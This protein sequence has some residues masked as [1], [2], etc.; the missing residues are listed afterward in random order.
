MISAEDVR[1]YLRGELAPPAERLGAAPAPASGGSAPQ[2]Q[3]EPGNIDVHRRPVHRNMGGSISTV[4]TIGIEQDGKEYVIPTI[5]DDG[6]ALNQEQAVE[7]FRR[8][9]KHLGAFADRA[10]A[11]AFAQSLHEDQAKEYSGQEPAP[12]ADVRAYLRSTKPAAAPIPAPAGA[13]L[14]DQL[15]PPPGGRARPA[16]DVTAARGGPPP[17]TGLAETA[18]NTFVTNLLP[19]SLSKDAEDQALERADP[20]AASRGAS[21]IGAA[22]AAGKVT[23]ETAYMVAL[24]PV[25]EKVGGFLAGI[26]PKVY[27]SQIV[28]P[29]ADAIVEKTG[30]SL[31]LA[32]RVAG[33]VAGAIEGIVHGAAPA[34]AFGA[35]HDVME[36]D[37]LTPESL[38]A[39]GAGGSVISGVL[40]LGAG[41][42]SLAKGVAAPGDVAQT[43]RDPYAILGVSPEASA[44]EILD[45]ARRRS[46][47]FHPDQNPTPGAEEVFKT[48]QEA[49]N[50]ALDRIHSRRP[51]EAPESP[52][53]GEPPAAPQEAGPV[54]EAQPAPEQAPPAANPTAPGEALA[55]ELGGYQPAKTVEDLQLM[56]DMGVP[57]VNPETGRTRRQEFAEQQRQDREQQ[58]PGAE[59]AAA[60]GNEPAAPE[61][62]PPP[63]EPQPVTTPE[64]RAQIE[65]QRRVRNLTEQGKKPNADEIVSMYRDILEQ[66]PVYKAT[67]DVP[68]E[69]PRK[70]ISL[71]PTVPPPSSAPL[72]ARA[73]AYTV[74]PGKDL[75]VEPARF[76]YK[77][78]PDMA[79]GAGPE[80]KGVQRW[81]PDF[82]GVVL[83]WRDPAD[84]RLKVVN[85]HH[86]VDLARRLGVDA[87]LV[88]EINA[89]SAEEARAIGAMTNIA[90]GRG[91][92][93]DAAKVFRDSGMT[94]EEIERR[95]LP[96]RGEVAREGLALAQV[97]PGLFEL[98]ARG[99]EPWRRIA[100]LGKSGLSQPEQLAT[101]H[102]VQAEEAKGRR[103][104]NEQIEELARFAK[105]AETERVS[106][107]SLFGTETVD[108]SNAVEKARL[109]AWAKDKL[110]SQARLFKFVS[111]GERAEQLEGAGV[112]KVDA[113][114][115]GELAG[116]AEQVAEV[117]ERLSASAGPVS[118]ALNRALREIKA[119]ASEA[120]VRAGL[121]E[122]I[123]G[124]VQEVLGRGEGAGAGRAGA[125]DRDQPGLGVAE[126]PGDVYRPEAGAVV[127][128]G[129]NPYPTAP[130]PFFSRLDRAIERA[131]FQRAPAVQWLG[132]LRNAPGGLSKSE[133]D[134]TQLES[135]LGGLGTEKVTGDEVLQRA[136]Q[137]GISL[138]ETVKGEAGVAPPELVQARDD[139]LAAMDRAA[140][141]ARDAGEALS[142]LMRKRGYDA[143]E[144]RRA[145]FQLGDVQALAREEQAAWARA[146]AAVEAVL[147]G[148]DY[149]GFGSLEEA[150]NAA[151]REPDSWDMPERDVAI[152]RRAHEARKAL[153][154][155][156]D[157]ELD[158]ELEAIRKAFVRAE[159]AHRDATAAYQRASDAVQEHFS[160]DRPQYAGWTEPGGTNYREILVQLK[161]PGE[162]G[163]TAEAAV[164]RWKEAA[165]A[166]RQGRF[167][168][169][170]I[171]R[172][173]ADM[174]DDPAAHYLEL[175]DF[176]WE[177]PGGG[178]GR[179]FHQSHFSEPNVVVH[180]RTKDRERLT[181]TPQ[182]IDDIERR[183][184]EALPGV[185][186]GNIASGAPLAAVRKGAIT[187]LE[188]AQFA[189]ARGYAN[190]QKGAVEKVLGV[191][192]FQSD[193][194]REGRKQ[195]Y[196]TGD[197]AA[198]RGRIL[199]L[200]AEERAI[201]R[202]MA[203]MHEREIR[204]PDAESELL[205]RRTELA[206]RQRELYHE[207][208]RLRY[209]EEQALG[210]VPDQPFKSASEWVE[211]AFKR[212]LAEAVAGGYDR[213]SWVNGEMSAR[214]Y[215]LRKHISR[216]DY[217]EKASHLAAY[218]SRGN[219]VIT[220][221][222]VRP[223]DLPDLIGAELA[224]R[225][226]E[227]Q[228]G[229]QGFT[230]RLVPES[231]LRHS[232]GGRVFAHWDVM[233]TDGR[234]A[235]S[236][237]AEFNGKPLTEA[238]AIQ[239]VAG[240]IRSI[241]GEE[242]TVGG[243]SHLNL[244]DKVVP[245]VARDVLKKIGVNARIEPIR[246]SFAAHEGENADGTELWE[247]DS[248]EAGH[249]HALR[250][251]QQVLSVPITPE[252]RA[253]VRD[254]GLRVM[255]RAPSYDLF[256]NAVQ[257]PA[258]QGD[259]LKTGKPQGVG[260][261]LE[262]ARATVSSL[263]GRVQ[264][265]RATVGELRRYEEARSLVRRQEG[266]G[267]DA[268]E[269]G[270][271]A[272]EEKP[273]LDPMVGDL[274][275]VRE[276][277]R[278]TRLNAKGEPEELAGFG[279]RRAA[280]QASL[281]LEQMATQIELVFHP[282]L[283]YQSRLAR[284]KQQGHHVDIRGHRI[285]PGLKGLQQTYRLLAPFRSPKQEIFHVILLDG[286]GRVVAHTLETSGKVDFVVIGK[287]TGPAAAMRRRFVAEV[288]D[289][290]RRAGAKVVIFAHNHPSGNPTPS[291]DDRSITVSLEQ[292]LR[293]LAP[294][295]QVAGHMVIDH[296]TAEW[297][298]T[299]AV[300][301]RHVTET[302]V[303]IPNAGVAS[304]WLEGK[305]PSVRSPEDVARAVAAAG[306]IPANTA[307]MVWLDGQNGTI[308]L[309]PLS[310][311]AVARIE[312]W[313]DQR[314]T[315]IGAARGILVT[316]GAPAFR[317]SV[318]A[319]GDARLHHDGGIIDVLHLDENPAAPPRMSAAANGLLD[320]T[321]NPADFGEVAP[322]RRL[323]EEGPEY[324]AGHD[325]DAIASELE[326]L[327]AN[328]PTDVERSGGSPAVTGQPAEIPTRAQTRRPP[329]PND[330]RVV[331]AP[332][333][334]IYPTMQGA[335]VPAGP[336]KRGAR[337]RAPH[338]IRAIA[339]IT[340]A[341]GRAIPLRVGRMGTRSA[342]GIF[343][344]GPEVMRTRAAN[345][346]PTAA[347]EAAH[348][349]EK[350]LYG[351]KKGGP[352]KANVT[353][354]DKAQQDELVALG[355]ALYGSTKPAGG[356]KREGFA[357]YLR[358]WITTD[359]DAST[360]APAFTSWWLD[361]LDGHPEIKKQV[362]AARELAT[363]W[364][365]QGSRVRAEESV[366]DTGSIEERAK[367]FGRAARSLFT[368]E[369]TVEAAQPLYELA[370]AAEEKIGPLK[371]T[372]DPFLITSALRSTHHAR[373]RVM[374]EDGMIDL[375]GNVVGDPLAAIKEIIKPEQRTDFTIYLWARRA[376]KLWEG[377][378]EVT[379]TNPQTGRL[380][381]VDVPNPR[382]P[383]L[384]LEDAKQILSELD[385][386][387]F[388]LA[389]S[390][391]YEWNDGV[392]N[393]A[394]QASP[395]F[396]EIVQQVRDGDVGDY[397]P[398]HRVFDD[399][400]DI[401]TRSSR[402][403]SAGRRSPVKRLKGSG[404]EIKDPFPVMIA[405]AAATVRAAHQ[406]AV[407]DA[408]LKL[409]RVEG[410]GYLIEEVPVDQVPA[411][412][413][414]VGEI[415]DR[416]NKELGGLAD[417]DVR[418][419][420]GVKA[421]A[422]AELL[423]KALTFFAPAQ[424]P[425]GMDPIVPLW[426]GKRVRW[427]YVD[428]KLYEALSSLDVYRLPDV[429]GFPLLEWTLGKSASVVRLG[430]TG[431]RASFGLIWNPFR[432]VQ[433]LYVNTRSGAVAPRLFYTWLKAMKDGALYRTVGKE[434]GPYFQAFLRLGGD[435]AQALGEDTQPAR[436]A[437][438]RLFEGRVVRTIDPR[439][440]LDWF[441]D[442]VQAP[443]AAPRVAE[444]ELLAEKV[445]WK[446]GQPMTLAQSFELLLGA[447]QV[448]TD[449]TAAGE[450]ARVA[451]RMIPFFNAAIQGPR[452]NMRAAADHPARFAWRGLQLT[453]VSL[454]LWWA[455]KDEDWWKQ[456]DY[457][458]KFANWH[459]PFRNPVTGQDELLRLPR[460][461]E[462]GLVFSALP[463]AI[464]DSWY[465]ADPRSAEEFMTYALEVAAPPMVP[466][467][468][469]EV[470]EQARNKD[471]YFNTPIVP[472]GELDLPASLQYNE[473]TNRASVL[474]GRLFADNVSPETL[475]Q[476]GG[477][478]PRR[479]D[480]AINGLFG[481]TAGDIFQL[482]GLG[483]PKK[484]D[485]VGLE[486]KEPADIPV[487]GRA[488]KRGGP[489][490][491]RPKAFD[492]LY[493]VL[494]E[495]QRV[496]AVVGDDETVAHAQ[497]RLMLTDAAQAV[498]ALTLVRRY[499]EDTAK[500]RALTQEALSIAE[501][502]LEDAKDGSVSRIDF[503][504]L[505]RGAQ[506][507]AD[508]AMGKQPARPA[509]ARRPSTRRR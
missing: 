479:I 261:A 457:R 191:E 392:L 509:G 462:V 503:E 359:N 357:E 229:A 282:E 100:I 279:S 305:Q 151:I 84:G 432:D 294:E 459:M 46:T 431:L 266:K 42:L 315:A 51:F 379:R 150:V 244:Y 263:E 453:A 64:E 444:L 26:G 397:V 15:M 35:L 337:V 223:G 36:G 408:I 417:V 230:A 55:Q 108:Q 248:A 74:H 472:Q 54:Q 460:S 475:A 209:Q 117:Y 474:L 171:E 130:V 314:K 492:D 180:I 430:T 219:E 195:G 437:A 424:T 119:G 422:E 207:R 156:R 373:A 484:D 410:L 16:A 356:Y 101:W 97:H 456:M 11:D 412:Q 139:A 164:A 213:L 341:A 242:L 186:R 85:G 470:Y 339:K 367:K 451:N 110:R 18:W 308:A 454:L 131:P 144:I 193:W 69:A 352:W 71:P 376:E 7:Q 303:S 363:Q 285:A 225:V 68:R 480:H 228:P 252:L 327:T 500:Q 450:L 105:T 99:K 458:E 67:Q 400:D 115:A 388:Q 226:M 176:G 129:R 366:I 481:P 272:P 473:F 250:N 172:H 304:P 89:S 128:S 112:G 231:D 485:L 346:I 504:R 233:R 104:T 113:E 2:G 140:A 5:G 289:R 224:K 241:S 146:R 370:R 22:G 165:L 486:I 185:T 114:R 295:L 338:V 385:S 65:L 43:V 354:V 381:T 56:Q 188:A 24:G 273:E 123:R 353:G 217:D 293:A 364:R 275:K 175:R 3:I 318:H 214:R 47:P 256:G 449:F 59:L 260:A 220:R 322:V 6:S 53:T 389:A 20:N 355:K 411:A 57:Q 494:G 476:D 313:F 489:L 336:I 477:L 147:E 488:F 200:D 148:G 317:G 278:I 137:N 205:P 121:L 506:A 44:Q 88:R 502:A 340:E 320:R 103:L 227:Q 409:S 132:Y 399:L 206:A 106:Q 319:V 34:A 284:V 419:R 79:T 170:E 368:L 49:K 94:R 202:E 404:R 374:V 271:R 77:D 38:A 398:V 386:P 70:T 468:P 452:A 490:G 455:H 350:V 161:R 307:A 212:A 438:R 120:T 301:S 394:A 234:R 8:T 501:K 351:W 134:W 196:R 393:Y 190:D 80:L 52:R 493:N 288:A 75:D 58:A 259:L 45:A 63:A 91:T 442:L 335:L 471:T 428:G 297:I 391:V 286:E 446:P 27:A 198:I 365:M 274:F 466:P 499:T 127:P 126:R 375:A 467:I 496:R 348:A 239:S 287:G 62:A 414:S 396:A 378:K 498:T 109:S 507:R 124:A 111:R 40:G 291:A 201:D 384:S 221:H 255:E 122:S 61:Q 138:Y 402:G 83:A 349:L 9:G 299:D 199:D 281:E 331:E 326:R 155:A 158:P 333:N 169:G 405:Q 334:T 347:H 447:K 418:F 434:P 203:A 182:Q 483:A 235:G 298:Q 497:L 184:T 102:L 254:E 436:R 98:A 216:V 362:G 311:Q 448:T 406:R 19:G 135:W 268:G 461:F 237:P 21:L 23:K 310:G 145:R 429:A 463:E 133:L 296:E 390:K 253:R 78:V 426:D 29:I 37:P 208:T 262:D 280:A 243:E 316:T 14:A 306:P 162:E 232:G 441:R 465:Q 136:Q 283:S 32:E 210:G 423:G 39:W 292:G 218:D 240:S 330:P 443:E 197:V 416:L 41:K 160:N 168:P 440:W 92:P 163:G 181:Y 211:L 257:Q 177:A 30:V 189:H 72:P 258:E 12:E 265:G 325:L 345:D 116:E 343:K 142:Q 173:A 277:A 380:E 178:R 360:K 95:G 107:D 90:E 332:L 194:Q 491:T 478:S 415:L 369:K 342:L 395:S 125:A 17:R 192:E 401:W 267:L 377:T 245:N 13:Q 118:N 383:G 425:K 358:L 73:G 276:G 413:Q 300:D 372:D 25:V 445:G 324:Q 361:F 270:A 420:Q 247:D 387:E 321:R 82:A 427:F 236:A 439:N 251:E 87:M 487:V 66:D 264:S 179:D 302:K 81:D 50:A 215:D 187:P 382:N 31:P 328:E 204:E 152:F 482:L 96:L 143:G 269:I 433:T 10:S 157:G 435:M 495:A 48:I 403:S 290:A 464:M 60:L 149:L 174:L 469:L 246:M 312:H 249:L 222:Q 76:Q 28:T 407:L 4:A 183:I 33:R 1:K 371:S 141:V 154:R 323:R 159:N 505:R 86:R 421:D 238:E 329:D 93:V 309:E 166:G 344:V 153:T 508:A 167:E